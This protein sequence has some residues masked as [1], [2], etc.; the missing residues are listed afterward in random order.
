MKEKL[1]GWEQNL[2]TLVIGADSLWGG[3]YQAP[4]GKDHFVAEPWTREWETPKVYED[5]FAAEL[6]AQGGVLGLDG[7]QA[8]I[9]DFAARHDLTGLAA[10]IRRKAISL[11]RHRAYFINNL[12]NSLSLIVLTGL[13]QAKV[14]SY[15]F[16]SFE[17]RYRAATLYQG[18]IQLVDVKE[19][20]K[21]LE[22][23]LSRA[24]YKNRSLL[25]AV[26]EWETAH[27]RLDPEQIPQKVTEILSK[28]IP[29]T[30]EQ[31]IRHLDV[32]LKGDIWKRLVDVPYNGFEFEMFSM[33]SRPEM[34]GSQAYF[35]GNKNQRPALRGLFEYN[36]DYPMT[37]L[38]LIALCLHEVMPGHY[39]HSVA[40]DLASN[41][42]FEATIPTMCSPQVALWEGVAQNSI[43]FLFDTEDEAYATLA[44]LFEVKEIDLRIQYALDKLMDAAKHNAPIMHQ[45]EGMSEKKI[46]EYASKTCALTDP[47]PTK[48]WGWAKHPLIGPMYA[49]S[50]EQ[51]RR[52]V[53]GMIKQHGRIPAAIAA[54]N[55]S[56]SI[57]DIETFQNILNSSE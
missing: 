2:A 35:G 21:N 27:G 28:V 39:F 18:S 50:Y 48:I 4:S 17:D 54:Y 42:G 13:A 47:L 31:L 36:K 30:K 10:K 52:V 56:G 41:L 15:S 32:Q 9:Q 14:R 5:S 1:R 19:E 20:R 51:G 11:P 33:P 40:T 34:T 57:V 43:G 23:L 44:K 24:G 45:R 55:L 3:D 12:V 38:G 22:N 53:T 8:E 37:Y 6:R 49:C 29:L 16:P 26:Q 25:G 7:R 46:R